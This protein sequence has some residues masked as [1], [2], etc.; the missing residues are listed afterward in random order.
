[1]GPQFSARRAN[2]R[3][4]LLNLGMAVLLDISRPNGAT[5]DA[6]D[7][8][9]NIADLTGNGVDYYQTADLNRSWTYQFDAEVGKYIGFAG[10]QKG[11][12]DTS[13]YLTS[14]DY[15]TTTSDTWFFVIRDDPDGWPESTLLAQRSSGA[16]VPLLVVK[17]DNDA[18]QD[19]FFVRDANG[20]SLNASA[21]L[22]GGWAI[23][24]CR[25]APGAVKMWYGGAAV[26]QSGTYAPTVYPP[27]G[28]TD[29][30]N[31]VIGAQQNGVGGLQGSVFFSG[32]F[33]LMAKF[34]S[35]LSDGVI[36]AILYNLRVE[37]K[38]K[39]F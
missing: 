19:I 34:N 30:Y 12:Q 32:K 22:F 14:A 10:G 7:N 39:N 31:P 20:A 8:I 3:F 13:F 24:V 21:T 33:G 23:L 11:G 16:G 27:E 2:E 5:V 15:I 26:S 38:I 17:A 18:S 25:R 29:F 36:Q 1:M 9:T 4:D 37:W 6:S 35:A 28:A